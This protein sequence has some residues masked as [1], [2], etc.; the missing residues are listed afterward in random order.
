MGWLALPH[1][2]HAL[3]AR[4]LPW[5]RG[6]LRRG[7]TAAIEALVS[8]LPSAL[9]IAYSLGY[10]LATFSIAVLYLYRRR[11]RVDRFLF[12]FALGVL[13]CYA[14]S[15]SGLRSRLA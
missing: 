15:R 12:I 3:E 14:Q 11:D 2:G 13:L 4:W 6:L 8:V 10:A 1:S 7:V 5:D 9:E